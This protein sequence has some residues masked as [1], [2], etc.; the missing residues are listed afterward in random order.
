MKRTNDIIFVIIAFVITLVASANK[1]NQQEESTTP[2]EDVA[3]SYVQRVDTL[4]LIVLYPQY[5]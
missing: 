3:Q 1:P 4:G 5:E 2:T